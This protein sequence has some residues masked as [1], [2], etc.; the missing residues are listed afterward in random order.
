MPHPLP[1]EL[2]DRFSVRAA[3]HAGVSP[4]RLRRDDL[5]KPFS[6]VR[7][8][9][10]DDSGILLDRLGQARGDHEREHIAKALAYVQVMRDGE[11]FSH[12]TAAALWDIPVPGHLLRGDA[13]VDVA[14]HGARKYPRRNGVRGHE[15][16]VETAC[17]IRHPLLGVRVATPATT[18]AM[19]GS[20]LRNPRDVVA[21]ADAVV[22]EWRVATPLAS[23]R[24]L[25]A[26]TA[27]GRR[28]GVGM[29]RE[30]LPLVRTRSASLP[31]THLRLAIVDDGL[32]EPLLNFDVVE[33]GEKI[34][35]VDLAYPQWRVAIEYEGEHHLTDPLQWARDIR[36]YERLEAAGWRVV[37]VTKAELFG[38]N[39]GLMDR[40]HAAIRARS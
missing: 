23:L 2:G 14:T 40:I 24:E 34:A 13:A 4:A 33:A 29:L 32:P 30:A 18:W 38:G 19:L 25:H 37:R 6:G 31:E 7:V 5:H 17:Y 26:V 20:V 36:R 21:S 8:R 11:F 1:D 39:R 12:V 9:G 27:S 28:V 15:C 22:R 10:A 3:L 35:C 16:R